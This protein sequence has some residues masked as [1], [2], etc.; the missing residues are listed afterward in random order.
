MGAVVDGLSTLRLVDR[1]LPGPGSR[2]R[3]VVSWQ[4]PRMIPREATVELDFPLDP[5]AA[6]RLRWY[7]EDYG[8]FRA[9]PAPTIASTTE[10]ELA[11]LG[12]DL[13]TAMFGTG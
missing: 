7:L 11:Q 6:E 2:H 8:E 13:F 12:R 4:S 9:D 10:R 1:P 3:V 5:A